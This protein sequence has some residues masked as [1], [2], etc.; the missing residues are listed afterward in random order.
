M[1]QLFPMTFIPQGIPF[2]FQFITPL[3]STA[4]PGTLSLCP[5][6]DPEDDPG[7]AEG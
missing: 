7:Q 4:L 1:F 6:A 5:D 2:L 3:R